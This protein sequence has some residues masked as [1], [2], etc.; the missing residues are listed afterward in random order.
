[1]NLDYD[2]ACKWVT[3]GDV[4]S[5]LLRSL[6]PHERERPETWDNFAKAIA[7]ETGADPVKIAPN[8]P[9]LSTARVSWWV[10]AV[11]VG[12]LWALAG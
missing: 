11:I 10:L 1:M 9:L 5:S 7:S 8:S 12:A 2:E 3:A 4:S 6:P